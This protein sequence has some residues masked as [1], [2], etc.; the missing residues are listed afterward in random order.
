MTASPLWEACSPLCDEKS[1]P[2]PYQ[3]GMTRYDS[4]AWCR[5]EQS[6]H[7]IRNRK[8]IIKGPIIIYRLREGD[9]IGGFGFDTINF[10]RSLDKIYYS[11]SMAVKWKSIFPLYTMFTTANLPHF[12][13]ETMWFFSQKI[14]HTPP[15]LRL[16]NNDGCPSTAQPYSWNE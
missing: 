7:C 15:S 12:P 10:T 13:M 11:H 2:T 3:Q 6:H 1:S 16:L 9:T 14:P 8:Y 4:K 5:R